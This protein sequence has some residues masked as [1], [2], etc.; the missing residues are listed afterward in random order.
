MS[1]VDLSAHGVS[2]ADVR[3]NLPPARL[4]EEAIRYEPDSRIAECGALVAYSGPKTGRSP[5]DKRIVRRPPSDA[6][7]WWGTVN[8]PL[9][10][11]SFLINRERAVDYLNTRPHVYCFDGFAGWAPR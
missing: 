1:S 5:R 6:D 8:V 10:A 9:T 11:E 4:Y 3:R 2:V 7:V